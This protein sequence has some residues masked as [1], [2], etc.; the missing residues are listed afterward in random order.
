MD[1]KYENRIDSYVKILQNKFKL[2]KFKNIQLKI[3]DNII[4]HKRD[5][6]T[7]LATGYG[8]SLCY[9][10]P[11]I[12]LNKIGLIISPLISLMK[13]QLTIL[14]KLNIKAC[15]YNSS[16]PNIDRL[17]LEIL[18][19]YYNI[20]YITPELL[21]KSKKIFQQ[22][23]L[24]DD[25]A[26]VAIDESH[27]I[28]QYGY[29]FRP[30]YRL[31]N[32]IREWLNENINYAVPILAL[33]GTATSMVEKDIC[34][35]LRLNNPLLIKSTFNRPNL[36]INIIYKNK[37]E[38]YNLINNEITIIYCQTRKE[39]EELSKS[40]NTKLKIN[41]LVYHSGLDINIRNDVYNQFIEEKIRCIIATISFGM[42]INKKN[43]RKII[44]YGVPKNLE[45]YYQ[46]IGRAGRDGLYSICYLLYSRKDILKN[47]SHINN[48]QD[49]KYKKIK[50][51]EIKYMEKFLYST[52]CRRQQLLQYFGEK[53][54]NI[55][56]NIKCCDNCNGKIYK[57][58][59]VT[60]QGHKIISLI[61]KL[62]YAGYSSGMSTC[63]NIIRGSK[64]K[65]IPTFITKYD[66][67][68]FSK[69][70]YN[71]WEKFIQILISEDIIEEQPNDN[72]FGSILSCTLYGKYIINSLLPLHFKLDN[73]LLDEI[74]L[75]NKLCI[76]D[77]HIMKKYNLSEEY[78]K[79]CENNLKLP[80]TN[81]SNNDKLLYIM[82]IHHGFDANIIA[83]LLNKSKKNIDN[84][85]AKLGKYI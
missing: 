10:F 41:T 63:I 5:I 15:C 66:Y 52:K 67:F 56:K 60:I 74:D 64:S 48:I 51:D 13:D 70:S 9:Q 43:I 39:T 49:I 21:I 28:Y 12:Y 18:S 25:L 85:L 17:K 42:G 19:G 33:T 38:I 11:P 58:F 37:K 82:S 4:Y 80:I 53:Y 32:C 83:L 47:K 34:N 30:S 65:K 81:L 40:I 76:N 79:H 45:S 31:L 44:H 6:C 84:S 59:D 23:Q 54:N 75:N 68:A 77:K 29:D 46:E 73:N 35:S 8:K 26:L 55:K 24:C 72:S 14:Q 3:I 20:V 1:Q 61:D 78:I 22:L 69:L 2:N 62:H 57:I 71:W 36:D 7:V 16:V 27:C 50:N